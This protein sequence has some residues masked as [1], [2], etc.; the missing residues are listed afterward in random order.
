M[1]RLPSNEPVEGSS[2]SSSYR[3]GLMTVS[4]GPRD[5][6][7]GHARAVVELAFG[8][9]ATRRFDVRYWDGSVDRSPAT[10][11]AF[12]L[13]VNRPGALRRMLLPPSELSIVESYLSG[14]IDIDGEMEAAMSLADEIGARVR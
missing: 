3:R 6:L 1:E 2:R 12:R 7:L 5:R 14:D 8:P 13:G 4:T 10:S 9:L 11:P